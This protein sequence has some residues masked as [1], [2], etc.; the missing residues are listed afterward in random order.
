[1]KENH[2][3]I[4]REIVRANT[5][6][7]KQKK[8]GQRKLDGFV[9]VQNASQHAE[10]SREGILKAV[11]EFIVCDDQVGDV[12]DTRDWCF[13]I[14]QSLAVMNKAT[15]RNCLVAMRPKTA[16]IDLPS[17]HDISSYIH[18]AF[19]KFLNELKGEIQVIYINTI[20]PFLLRLLNAVTRHH[21]G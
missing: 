4:P 19:I 15:F 8:E 17:T 14:L 10:F 1:L 6:A 9:R 3:A 12:N 11:A 20:F 13:N 2:H 16:N 21:S 18:N 5:E 7:R